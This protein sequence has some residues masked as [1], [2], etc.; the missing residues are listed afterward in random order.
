[1]ETIQILSS[2]IIAFATVVYVALTHKILRT[3]QR[4]IL[5]QTRPYIV[6]DLIEIDGNLYF[7]LKNYGTR[8][9]YS[10][11]CETVPNLA[12]L[13]LQISESIV[14][15][16]LNQDY[17][18]PGSEFLYYLNKAFSFS[19]KKIKVNIKIHY[20]DDLKFYYEEKYALAFDGR[21]FLRNHFGKTLE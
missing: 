14:D 6:A 19:Q 2:L 15:E 9:A 4:L 17:I 18:P 5:E 12:E 20:N 16:M 10:V 13:E 8:G 1:M 3:N 21:L 7:R 11:K